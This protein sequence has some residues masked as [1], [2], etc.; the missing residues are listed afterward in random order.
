MNQMKGMVGMS[1]LEFLLESAQLVVGG[2]GDERGR[3]RGRWLSDVCGLPNQ[4]V[5]G[6]MNA[7]LAAK[8]LRAGVCL[9]KTTPLPAAESDI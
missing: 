5:G 1:V 7:A 4:A 2:G 9:S 6:E 3:R 8:Y